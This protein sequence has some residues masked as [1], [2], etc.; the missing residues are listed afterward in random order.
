MGSIG[1][2]YAIPDNAYAIRDQ[3]YCDTGFKKRGNSCISIYLSENAYISGGDSYCDDGFGQYGD[4]CLNVSSVTLDE[5]DTVKQGD[6]NTPNVKFKIETESEDD[7][8][9]RQDKENELKTKIAELELQLE[10]DK[11][12]NTEITLKSTEKYETYKA[13]QESQYKLKEHEYNQL[14]KEFEE[15]HDAYKKLKTANQKKGE[16]DNLS[17]Q[18]AFADLEAQIKKVEKRRKEEETKIEQ[19]SQAIS[20]L[21]NQKQTLEVVLSN[22]ESE[23]QD[24]AKKKLDR[25]DE[26]NDIW[27]QIIEAKNIL[28]RYQTK[29]N[30]LKA[31]VDAEKLMDVLIIIVILLS[32]LLLIS[33]QS[34]RN[35]TK[36]VQALSNKSFTE[37][38]V[39]EEKVEEEKVDDN[40]KDNRVSQLKLLEINKWT[41]EWNKWI[42]TGISSLDASSVMDKNRYRSSRELIHEKKSQLLYYSNDQLEKLSEL[43]KQALKA[44][45]SKSRLTKLKNFSFEDVENAGLISTVIMTQ[46][47]RFAAEIKV[48]ES[49]YYQAKS[50]FIP[51]ATQCELQHQLMITGLKHIDYWCYLEGYDGILIK[52][53]RNEVFINELLSLEI[54]TYLKIHS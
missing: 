38:K 31:T 19:I 2:S 54:K 18:K 5:V 24:A 53:D 42:S 14:E 15:L 45:R 12:R 21:N 52:V 10:R 22:F 36:K 11:A 3:W 4:K 51:K 17:Q 30:E 13:I 7:Q 6:G 9:L 50:G 41:Q 29:E 28:T 44:Y 26:L 40:K 46:D 27:A 47:C 25:V 49:S 33:L 8:K 35:L 37:E 23:V 48:D 32:I 20:D 39:E 43:E 34:R 16:R 1:L